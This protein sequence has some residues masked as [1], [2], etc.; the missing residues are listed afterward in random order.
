ME[1]VRSSRYWVGAGALIGLLAALPLLA[2]Q[3]ADD[4]YIHARIVENLVANG[5]PAF[6]PGDLFKASSATGYVLLLAALSPVFGTLTAIKVVQAVALVA[7]MVV[8][9]V[10]VRAAPTNRLFAALALLGAAPMVFMSAYLGMETTIVAA[11]MLS[12]ALALQRGS[13]GRA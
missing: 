7:T 5:Q 2:V 1:D 12:A 10:L 13:L 3:M 9:A 8:A 4:A 6:N 11:L